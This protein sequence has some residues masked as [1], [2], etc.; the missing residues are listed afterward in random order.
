M[1]RS[2]SC[3]FEFTEIFTTLQGQSQGQQSL[4]GQ[5][6]YFVAIFDINSY[7]LKAKSGI[8]YYLFL[9]RISIATIKYLQGLDTLLSILSILTLLASLLISYG[10]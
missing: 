7:F 3:Y 1:G 8:Q 6:L 9:K 2:G 5:S 4:Q 10:F